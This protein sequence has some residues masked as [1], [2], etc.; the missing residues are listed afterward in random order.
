M[1]YSIQTKKYEGP[2][3]L[4]MD[5]IHRN[6][7]DISDISIFEITEQYVDYIDNMEKFDLDIAS[8]FIDMASKLLEIKSR[9]ILYLK[10]SVDC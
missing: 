1:D 10:Y 5:L 7:I 8:D 6:K 2:M 4:L 9:Y 3:E